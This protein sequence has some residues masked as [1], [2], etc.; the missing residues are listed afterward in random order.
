[1]FFKAIFVLVILFVA[2]GLAVILLRRLTETTQRLANLREQMA[3]N[4]TK[5]SD[6]M[7]SVHLE[8]ERLRAQLE[9]ERAKN[10]PRDGSG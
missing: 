4:D 1:M 5:L 2:F 6:Q 8:Q 10:E 7:R 9:V 3:R